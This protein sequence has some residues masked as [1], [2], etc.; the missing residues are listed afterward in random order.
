MIPAED[1]RNLKSRSGKAIRM[2]SD[3][4]VY[5][6]FDIDFDKN[7]KVKRITT[8]HGN[9]FW[10]LSELDAL[11]LKQGCYVF[12]LRAARGFKPWY[13]G[14][15]SKGFKQET[16]TSHKLNH[17]NDALFRGNK[18]TPVLFFVAPFDNKRKVPTTELNHM[19]MEL[20]QFAVKRNPDLCNVQNT[21]SVPQWTIKGV[22]RSASGKPNATEKQFKKMLKIR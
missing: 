15:A 19:E 18:G 1:H 22:I 14:K 17:Y 20:I 8:R 2:A 7:G 21:K 9:N 11:K 3:L 6:P 10:A 12:G 4:K 13:V 5:G 16:F